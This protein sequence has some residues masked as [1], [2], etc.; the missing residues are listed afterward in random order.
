MSGAGGRGDKFAFKVVFLGESGVGKTCLATRF[1]K[2]TFTPSTA[3]TIGAAFSTTSVEIKGTVVKIQMWDTAGQERYHCLAPMYY[4]EAAG[5]FVVYDVTDPT[6][7]E[8]AKIWIQELKKNQPSCLVMLLGNKAD[9][10]VAENA[11]KC[12]SSEAVHK[13]VDEEKLM[14]MDVS[15]KTGQ[16]VQESLQM[17]AEEVMKRSQQQQKKQMPAPGTGGG[18]GSGDNRVVLKDEPA[19]TPEATGCSC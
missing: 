2:G 11:S 12:V 18:G 13:L 7:F 16:N 1:E 5:A 4:R 19:P 8:R 9:C 6:T 17:L 10:K 15:A 3:S 14:S